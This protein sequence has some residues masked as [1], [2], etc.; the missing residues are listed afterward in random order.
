MRHGLFQWNCDFAR[1]PIAQIAASGLGRVISTRKVRVAAS[2]AGAM[3]EMSPVKRPAGHR[4]HRGWHAQFQPAQILLGHLCDSQHGIGI[5]N[6]RAQITT[7]QQ[8][9]LAHRHLFDN[10]GNGRVE[11]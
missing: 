3:N 4:F 6:A 2:D 1:H 9:A 7:I 8:R 11:L 10:P 5:N